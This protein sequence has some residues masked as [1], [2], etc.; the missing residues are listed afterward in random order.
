[1]D[2]TPYL[3]YQ[4]DVPHVQWDVVW[5]E[6]KGKSLREKEE[7]YAV[8]IREWL[9]VLHRDFA[10]A[11]STYESKWIF[12]ST[13]FPPKKARDR[14]DIIIDVKNTLLD[15]YGDII[16]KEWVGKN[17]ILEFEDIDMYYRYISYFY[18]P[19][20]ERCK[21]KNM[22]ASGGCLLSKG[23][24]HIV[25]NTHARHNLSQLIAHE[26]THLLMAGYNLPSWL[27]E[28]LAVNAQ[29]IYD[30]QREL[31]I[32]DE[33]VE[34]HLMY[35]NKRKFDSFLRGKTIGS[36]AYSSL[37]YDLSFMMVREI[38][39]RRV[40]VDKLIKKYKECGDIVAALKETARKGPE[41]FTPPVIR[42]L[43]EE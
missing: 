16:P 42:Q 40:R 32:N 43:I 37:A 20:K 21:T 10:P 29:S 33:N 38:L 13:F 9:S 3:E 28:G 25:L 22:P 15:V 31:Y 5:E 8:L 27:N 11:N 36:P 41:E 34:K 1:M 35:W 14:L 7:T 30:R 24:L 26:M 6:L 4:E 18:T 39:T 19:V 2:C 23:Y 17:L 12:Y